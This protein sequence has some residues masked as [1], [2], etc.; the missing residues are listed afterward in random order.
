MQES[1]TQA[2]GAT[3]GSF[4]DEP[5]AF[6]FDICQCIRYIG[7]GESDMM[8]AFTFIF[9]KFCDGRIFRSRFEKF[10]FCLS[11][12]KECRF[13]FLIG[14]FFDV[15]AFQSENIFLIGKAVGNPLNSNPDVFDMGNIH[16]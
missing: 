5:N 2:F 11:Y 7:N 8:H 12:L 13:D 10:D 3:P 15:V 6:G 16:R 1:N 4:V 14:Y 9:Y